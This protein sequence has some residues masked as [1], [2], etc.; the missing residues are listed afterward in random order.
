MDKNIKKKMFERL[1]FIWEIDKIDD[2]EDLRYCYDGYLQQSIRKMR[3]AMCNDIN[4]LYHSNKSI[5]H[6][7]FSHSYNKRM[8]FFELFQRKKKFFFLIS[9]IRYMKNF[10]N[11]K[12]RKKS[13][14]RNLLASIS[15]IFF[16]LFRP[17]HI[18]RIAVFCLVL[19]CYMLFIRQSSTTFFST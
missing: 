8:F 1:E 11:V 9:T 2:E 12:I 19:F 17:V 16:S 4:V 10:S 3:M 15:P 14:A 5:S 18:E 7:N 13:T 6:T